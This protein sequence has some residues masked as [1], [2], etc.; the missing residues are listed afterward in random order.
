[1]LCSSDRWDI[2]WEDRLALGMM[3]FSEIIM[4]DF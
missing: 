1:M 3:A 2:G 4:K